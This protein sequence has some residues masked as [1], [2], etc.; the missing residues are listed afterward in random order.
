MEDILYVLHKGRLL[1][2]FKANKVSQIV[3][4]EAQISRQTTGPKQLVQPM[5]FSFDVVEEAAHMQEQEP[6]SER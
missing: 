2:N 6:K 4:K 1:L 3:E 5:G